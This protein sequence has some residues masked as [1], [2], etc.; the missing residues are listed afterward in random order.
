[1]VIAARAGLQGFDTDT[2]LAAQAAAALRGAGFMF[3]I[4]YLTR[5]AGQH[6]GDLSTSEALRILGAGLSLM[7]VQHVAPEGW[8]PTADLGRSNG[9]HGAENAHSV[10]FPPG[11][12]V[13]LD[14]EGV[15][16]GS[17]S[18]QVIDYCNAWFS[19]VAA[20]GFVPGLYVGPDAGLS[21]DELYWR[22]K[23]KH[24][25]RAGSRDLPDIPHRGYQ[26]F[27]SPVTSPVAGVGIDRDV[28]KNDQ[29]GDAILWLAPAGMVVA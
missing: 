4:R 25:W 20:A 17:A 18:Q 29:F 12:N 28:T 11:V 13:W 1:M 7:P 24:Y 23:V 21:G 15:V 6:P 26:M 5:G 27:Q 8:T 9:A 19:E 16:A 14:L 3:C 2:P 22:L 10:G